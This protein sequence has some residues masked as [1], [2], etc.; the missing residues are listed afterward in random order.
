MGEPEPEPEPEQRPPAPCGNDKVHYYWT[1]DVHPRLFCP[2]CA[3][4]NQQ[5]T[6]NRLAREAK[7]RREVEQEA[8]AQRIADI[9]VER[10][11]KDKYPPGIA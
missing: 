5:E 6:E 4:I 2:K 1:E 7:E 8:L 3:A 11:R 10:L 9:V